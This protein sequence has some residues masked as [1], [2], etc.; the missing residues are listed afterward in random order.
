MRS[1][2][3]AGQYQVDP[4]AIVAVQNVMGSSPFLPVL[5]TIRYGSGS[6]PGLGTFLTKTITT[7]LFF[8]PR[9]YIKSFMV[10]LQNSACPSL[11]HLYIGYNPMTK[12]KRDIPFFNVALSAC[13]GLTS[14]Q[15]PHL[16]IPANVFVEISLLP[17]LEDIR[18]NLAALEKLPSECRFQC[19]KTCQIQGETFGKDLSV[20]D[21]IA[22]NNLLSLTIDTDDPLTSQILHY[23]LR[24]LLPSRL[25]LRQF[26]VDWSWNEEVTEWGDLDHNYNYIDAM[27]LGPLLEFPNI[28][29]FEITLLGPLEINDLFLQQLALSCPTLQRLD[30]GSQ[31]PKQW[32][33]KVTFEGLVHLAQL[34]MELKE[35]GMQFC[36]E[37]IPDLD[38]FPGNNNTTDLS[39]GCSPFDCRLQSAVACALKVL[40]PRLQRISVDG[41][42]AEEDEE[43]P[44]SDAQSWVEV[45]EQMGSVEPVIWSKPSI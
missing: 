6:N 37:S 32:R 11:K 18:F 33:S 5:Q 44:F 28:Q 7:L 4:T 23:T 29:T 41:Q 2:D 13:R 30:L 3:M 16:P 1:L 36:V 27:T 14:L 39:V 20:I 17:K 35:V 8:E 40:F 10:A 22:T 34:C 26:I 21:T 43:G 15:M 9:A 42:L 45:G 12:P 31:S 25:S 24:R 38:D 19:L